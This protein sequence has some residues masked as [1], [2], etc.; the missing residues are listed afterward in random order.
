ML[1]VKTLYMVLGYISLALGI[2][3]IILPGLPTTPFLLLTAWLFL[4]GSPKMHAWIQQHRH[5]GP[6]LHEVQAGKG[7]P[8]YLKIGTLIVMASSVAFT[9]IFIL[10]AWWMR[11]LSILLMLA[12]A[13]VLIFVVPTRKKQLLD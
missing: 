8:M 13:Y 2:T 3:G 12:S 7:V 6:I 9:S 11:I 4:K 1:V 10:N 5:L